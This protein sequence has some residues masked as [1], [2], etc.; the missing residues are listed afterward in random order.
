MKAHATGPQ[1]T[2]NHTRCMILIHLTEF[3]SYNMLL[4]YM[5]Q[6]KNIYLLKYYKTIALGQILV[7]FSCWSIA[8]QNIYF[9]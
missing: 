7:K 1:I 2:S 5:C 4:Y 9:F 6:L 3:V 8:H